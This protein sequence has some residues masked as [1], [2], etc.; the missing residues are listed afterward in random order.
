M[1]VSCP[2]PLFFALL[3][4]SPSPSLKKKVRMYKTNVR[5][6]SSKSWNLLPPS[7]R[8][9]CGWEV[10]GRLWDENKD[11]AEKKQEVGVGVVG[12]IF[13]L[14]LNA[15]R[16]WVENELMVCEGLLS[17]GGGEGEGEVE[18]IVVGSEGLSGHE[19]DKEVYNMYTLF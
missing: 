8:F 6:R 19:I 5:Q 14:Q 7:T 15:L 3:S 17:E 2:P 10:G 1:Q 11:F 9:I 4:I 16:F 12:V 13:F 18:C